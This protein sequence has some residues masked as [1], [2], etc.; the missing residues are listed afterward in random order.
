[1]LVRNSSHLPPMLS[2]V[3]TDE[4]LST[5]RPAA[6]SDVSLK[7]SAGEE[8]Q[9][10]SCH[11]TTSPAVTQELTELMDDIFTGLTVFKVLLLKTV[12]CRKL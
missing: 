12:R 8:L 2:T 4:S 9:T 5:D 1:M 7:T 10:S 3:L 11:A 6:V